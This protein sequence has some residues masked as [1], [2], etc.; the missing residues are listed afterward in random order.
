MLFRETLVDPLLTRYSV[1]MIDEAHE[2]SL[3]TDVLLGVLKK[4]VFSLCTDSHPNLF[5]NTNGIVIFW[6]I[7][8]QRKRPDLCIIISS[9]TL[10]AEAFFEFFNSNTTD[11]PA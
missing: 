11:D 1:I 6:Y 10:D 4:Y 3:Y 5:P 8:I 9:A 2:R 7:R